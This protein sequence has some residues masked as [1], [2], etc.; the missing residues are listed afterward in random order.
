MNIIDHNHVIQLKQP[1]I[2]LSRF[3]VREHNHMVQLS[4]N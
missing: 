4:L 2:K 3:H 1:Q